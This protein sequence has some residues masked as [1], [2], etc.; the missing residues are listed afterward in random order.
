MWSESA[1]IWYGGEED[2]A[3]EGVEAVAGWEEA[4]N[5]GWVGGRELEKVA[6][7]DEDSEVLGARKGVKRKFFDED[8]ST[9]GKGVKKGKTKGRR[10][11]GR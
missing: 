1:S 8:V 2:V 7:G 4:V 9:P 10:G 3:A 11:K 6:V 5:G